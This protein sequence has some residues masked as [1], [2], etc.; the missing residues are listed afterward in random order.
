M[1]IV[2]FISLLLTILL[3]T[4]P[5]AAA[6][7]EGA[8]ARQA[9]AAAAKDRFADAGRFARQSKNALLVKLVRWMEFQAANS[10]A[11]FA[12]I[13]SFVLA[14]PDWPLMAQMQR[15][16]E[17]AITPATPYDQI[18]AWFEGR[19][20]VTVDGGMAYAR[21]LLAAGAMDK[22]ERVI[23]ETWIEGGF[24]VLQ[25]RQ[26]LSLFADSLSAEDHWRRLDRLLWDKADAPAQRMLLRVDPG[27]RLLAQARLALQDGKANPEPALAEVPVA[28]QD[29]PGLIFDR[30]RWRRQKDLDDDA[31]HLL[32]HPAVNKV[33]PDLW[34]QER[35]VLARRMLQK[36]HVTAAYRTAALH[37]LEPRST[38]WAEAEFLSGWIA[39]RFLEDREAG[40]RHFERMWEGATVPA[41]RSRA[42]YWAGRA[43][44]AAKDEAASREW[45]TRA[46]RFVTPYY[47]QLAASRL[48]VHDWP[49]PADPQPSQDDHR[50]LAGRELAGAARL[51]IEAGADEHLRAFFIR[52]NDIVDSPGERVLVARLAAKGRRED[53]GVIVARRAERDSVTLVEAGWPL[54]SIA[55]TSSPEPALVLALIRQESNF[56]REAVSSVGARGWMQLMP[57]TAKQVA[58]AIKV[59]FTPGKLNDPE[60]NVRLG[61]AYLDDL[62]ETFEGS[63][64]L[65]LAAYNAGPSRSKRWVRD[66]GD[67]REANVD[68][69][70]WIESIPFNET[71][72]YVQRVMESVPIYRRRLGLPAAASLEADLKRWARR[73]PGA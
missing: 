66:Y 30:V 3:L 26:F 61:R 25:E 54:P 53:L 56:H 21:A 28:F 18:R 6:E 46:A 43:A 27:R 9:F 60:Y 36:G 58:K 68:V 34:W 49:L 42:A 4:I 69:I 11:S 67:P 24:G 48:D 64:I 47:A 37:G 32:S 16:A 1:I 12:D 31:V 73:A 19:K 65:A 39:L 72:N 17:E 35:Q 20:P 71:R 59:T 70:D 10:S 13:A 50:R 2:R 23:R 7:G 41:S 62:L 8:L 22:A 29:D 38:G 45:F 52:L 33:R 44:E 57:A 55:A 14:N 63:Y 15:R 51:M 5:V 40:R